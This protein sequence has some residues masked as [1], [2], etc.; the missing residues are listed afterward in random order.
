[1][2][3][4]ARKIGHSISLTIPKSFNVQEGQSFEPQMNDDGSITFKPTHKNIFEGNWFNEDLHQKD[5][6][7][8]SGV[9]DS[10]WGN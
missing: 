6:L 7:T 2:V 5:T 10:E 1:M 9:L 8:D 3:V 4:K